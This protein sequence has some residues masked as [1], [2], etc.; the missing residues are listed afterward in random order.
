[1]GK[2]SFDTLAALP[3]PLGTADGIAGFLAV[4]YMLTWWLSRH[5]GPPAQGIAQRSHGTLAPLAWIVVIVCWIAALFAFLGARHRR[6]LLD[7]HTT[8]ESVVA[9]GGFDLAL[10]KDSRGTLVQCKNGKRSR[11][12]SA[13]NTKWLSIWPTNAPTW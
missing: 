12:V 5:G 4:R 6:R 1:M 8:L 11:R 13:S 3:S 9:G 2:H 7:T 10:L